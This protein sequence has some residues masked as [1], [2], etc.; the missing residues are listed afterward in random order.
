[1]PVL[2][3]KPPDPCDGPGGHIIYYAEG[4]TRTRA[5]EKWS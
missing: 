4:G 1:M 3:M 2:Q 5:D